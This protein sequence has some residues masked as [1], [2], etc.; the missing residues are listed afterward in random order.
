MLVRVVYTYGIIIEAAKIT[1]AEEK[2]KND[3]RVSG[4]MFTSKWVRTLLNRANLRR[5]KRTTEDKKIPSDE[6][7]KR[8]MSD[9]KMYKDSGHNKNTTFNMDETAFTYVIGPEH[10]YCPP[11]QSRVCGELCSGSTCV[12]DR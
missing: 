1:L 7:M 4:L 9:G 10:M 5:R 2:R 8:M 3:E 12:L 11:D 6:D